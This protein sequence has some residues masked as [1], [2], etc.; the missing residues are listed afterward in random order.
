[1]DAR[2]EDDGGEEVEYML[3]A[4]TH[5]MVYQVHSGTMSPTGDYLA[6]SWKE[7]HFVAEVCGEILTKDNHTRVVMRDS[8]TQQPFA[9]CAVEDESSVVETIDSSRYVVLKLKDP[10]T[11][12]TALIGLGWKER[13]AAYDFKAT[14][15][16][17]QKRMKFRKSQAEAK[18]AGG[19]AHDYNL[20]KDQKI[21]IPTKK[22]A[23]KPR[24]QKSAG[25]SGFAPPPAAAPRS[26][27]AA[28]ESA[29]LPENSVSQPAASPEADPFGPAAA[30][31]FGATEGVDPFAEPFDAAD[32]SSFDPFGATEAVDPFANS[33]TPV[34]EVAHWDPFNTGTS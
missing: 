18:P 17:H 26:I 5:G 12:R 7:E 24:R 2:E 30:D 4:F 15:Y 14:I 10:K 25:S 6:D 19:E 16:D 29:E 22:K 9:E 27:A 21:R 33:P 8:A 31:P 11:G 3:G 13:T 23:P 1:M 28:A 34:E 32:Q 20:S